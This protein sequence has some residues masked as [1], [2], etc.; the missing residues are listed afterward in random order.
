MKKIL[1][2]V[3]VFAVMVVVR[4]A[5]NKPNPPVCVI[6]HEAV[7]NELGSYGVVREADGFHVTIKFL[8]HDYLGNANVQD[9]TYT[10]PKSH[11]AAYE[12]CMYR[13]D[14]NDANKLYDVRRLINEHNL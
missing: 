9:F 3:V 7:L 10:T 5:G 11:E 8:I 2:V 4:V 1:I 13:E 12:S 6:G 14:M